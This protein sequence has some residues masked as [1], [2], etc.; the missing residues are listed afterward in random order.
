MKIKTVYF[1]L[2]FTFIFVILSLMLIVSKVFFSHTYPAN[3]SIKNDFL[4]YILAGS[5]IFYIHENNHFDKK[6]FFIVSGLMSLLIGLDCWKNGFNIHYF[7]DDLILSFW[8]VFSLRHIYFL[9][10]KNNALYLSIEKLSFGLILP[11]LFIIAF[12]FLLKTIVWFPKTND[13]L[14][15][16]IDAT[17]G[18]HPNFLASK[19]FLLFPAIIKQGLAMVYFGLPVALI[20][21][22]LIIPKN[23]R[24]DRHQLIFE[25]FTM[26]FIG[27]FLY[28]LFPSCG[29][30]CAFGQA[31]P[32]HPP[33]VLATPQTLMAPSL[34]SPENYFP[35]NC[36]PSLHTAW[37]ICIWRHLQKQGYI[38]RIV[39]HLWA[40][41][42]VFATLVIG[43]HY[44]IDII[45]GAAFALMVQGLCARSLR[46][47]LAGSFLFFGWVIII[48][49]GLSVLR[50]SPDTTILFYISTLF[51]SITLAREL[52]KTEQQVT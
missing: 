35:R 9:W 26:G 49:Y 6:L 12:I 18:F 8:A 43:E 7:F 30:L 5:C 47:T 20:L 28:L 42:C 23:K 21:T 11:L 44:L 27:I 45:T 14:L 41:C 50:F 13:H 16:A 24:R 48:Q 32:L 39:S 17:L 3:L 1:S 15:Y 51:I 19:T 52:S 4:F 38:T 37:I 31:W 29:P 2:F 10:K 46:T 33:P 34:L 40:L 36:L 25:F 22:Y